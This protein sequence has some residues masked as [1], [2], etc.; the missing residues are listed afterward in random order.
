MKSIFLGQEMNVRRPA[1]DPLQHNGL[2]VAHHTIIRRRIQI[3]ILDFI[4]DILDIELA[5][6]VLGNFLDPLVLG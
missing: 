3:E 5:N 4:S 6:L 2:Q 1:V